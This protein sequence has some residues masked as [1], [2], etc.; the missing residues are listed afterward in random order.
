VPEVAKVQVLAGSG[1]DAD[2]AVPGS[3]R[4]W[5]WLPRR[6]STVGSIVAL[7]L[8]WLSLSPALLPRSGLFQ[9]VVS[10]ASAAIGYGLGSLLTAAWN[11]VRRRSGGNAPALARRL[12]GLAAVLG[13]ALGLIWFAHWQAQLRT[14]MGMGPAPWPEYVV[15]PVLTVVI[16]VVLVGA[17]RM[18]VT[19]VRWVGRQVNRIAPPRVSALVG[20]VLVVAL[21]VGLLNGVVVRALM[22]AMNSSFAAVNQETQAGTKA[23]TT[24]QLSGGPS[25]LV[26]WDSLGRQ[27]RT[28]VAGGPTPAALEAFSAKPARQPIRAYTGLASADTVRDEAELAVRELDR[29]G[30]FDRA[31]LGVVTTTGSG[32]INES[33]ASALEYA[34]N[35]NTALVSMQYSYLPSAA[36]F[37]VDSNRAQQ[38]GRELFTVVFAKWE[39]LPAATR[40]KLVVFG[41]SLGSFGGEAAFSGAQDIRARIDGALFVGPTS[42]NPLWG[43]FVADRDPGTPQWLPTFEHGRTVRFVARPSDLDRPAQPWPLPRVVYLQYASDP[44]TWWSPSL[45]FRKPDWLREPRGYDVLPSTRWYPIITF[46]QL[47]ADMAISHDVPDGHGHRYGADPA[48][49]WAAILQP[50][51]WTAADTQRLRGVLGS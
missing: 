46:L 9:G 21:T 39:S 25:S 34:Y 49:A 17:V 4:H 51:G 15:I 43:S 45:L 31:V 28:F 19:A 37:V 38:A 24:P 40:P 7:V 26:T 11:G 3:R 16:F 33:S 5:R 32:W 42:S 36:S 6:Y 27:G 50:A 29:A 22:S 48:N 18:W 20:V 47:A 12:L 41:E 44:V 10:G 13:S 8:L 2:P 23:P 14:L 30:G 35:G 1:S